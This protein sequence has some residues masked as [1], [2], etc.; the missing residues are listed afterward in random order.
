MKIK[1]MGLKLSLIVMLMITAIIISTLVLISNGV[2]SLVNEITMADARFASISLSK[3]IE[4]S[5][6]YAFS[7]AVIIANEPTLAE[8]VVKKDL[9][10][11]HEILNLDMFDLDA[12]MIYDK[13]GNI[14][15][16]E[17]SNQNSDI[18]LEKTTVTEILST[19][20]GTGTIRKGGTSG[21]YIQG[22]AAIRDE[23]RQIVGAVFCADDLSKAKYV[24]DIKERSNCEVTIFNGD[25]RLNTT[26]VDEH[27]KRAIGTKAS[28]EVVET[29]MSKQEDYCLRLNLCMRTLQAPYR[30][31]LH[32]Y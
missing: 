19:G 7:H 11:L 27:G 25:T 22:S 6:D 18:G 26:L 21:L 15:L 10:L 32:Q 2:G 31:V 4:D 5:E 13:D 3:A 12:I 24:D 20:K 1:S 17:N 16:N 28:A 29:V 9:D 23:N 30:A 8:A 14:L